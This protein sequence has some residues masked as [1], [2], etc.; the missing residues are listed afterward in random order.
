MLLTIMNNKNI[1]IQP[2]NSTEAFKN[3]R[4]E[5]N[6]LLKESQTPQ[7]FLLWEWMFT[8][9][10]T[11]KNKNSKLFILTLFEENKLIAIAPFY[12]QS[13]VALINSLR[14]LGEG[15]K[16][17]DRVVTVYPDIIIKTGYLKHVTTA[18]TEYLQKQNEVKFNIAFFDLLNEHS[19]LEKLSKKLNRNFNSIL[20]PTESQ[21]LI[22]LPEDHDTYI[23]S[24]S[25]STRKQFRMKLKRIEKAGKLEITSEKS[26]TKGL[27][28]LEELHRKR[29]DAKS[30]SNIFDS[31]K[32]KLFH[33]RLCERFQDQDV[34]QF[35]IM[36]H[37]DVV[38][39][40]SY[41]LSYN[42][43][44]Y[45]YLSGF[46]S[47]DDQRFSPMFIFDLLEIKHL[48][49]NGYKYYDLLT[50]EST[51]NYKSKFNA[52]TKPVYRMHL[53]ENGVVSMTV[54]NYLKIRPLLAK[55]YRFLN[56]PITIPTS[57]AS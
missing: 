36:R 54:S 38:I 44:I 12:L 3:M 19:A 18:L 27:E 2:I 28:I 50:S 25:R 46:S 5:W 9:W 51:N 34:L 39:A 41:N 7:P 55:T 30:E 21:F 1:K 23:N 48:I 29:W 11:Y 37:D 52:N 10:E 22:Q 43:I 17:S 4:H 6:S 57:P 33:K 49:E 47:S 16:I 15:E 45:S 14:M 13:Q 42:K 20:N 8:W 35:R 56:K 53:L 24:L 26:L 31:E 40:A 32:F